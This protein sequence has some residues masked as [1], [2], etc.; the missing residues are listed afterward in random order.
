MTDLLSIIKGR[1]SV[2]SFLDKAIGPEFLDSLKEALIWAPSAGNLQSRFF[3]F[4]REREVK[5]RLV[6]L[7][8]EQQFISEAQ[9][10]VVACADL[11][12]ASAY[13]E[14]GSTL[15]CIQ[16]V[17]CSVQNMMLMAHSLG[18]GSVWVGS[19][20]EAGV[21]KLLGLPE[22]LRPVALVP[23]GYPAEMPE[24]TER[25]GLDEATIEI[26]G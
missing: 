25:V 18:L 16:D 17:A 6:E 13:G 23:V 14:R 20:D 9:V 8:L 22:Y 5:E 11:R 2:R 19:F 15:Y 1:R 4:I 21:S 3:Y 7:A 10:V 24:A 26:D 12:K